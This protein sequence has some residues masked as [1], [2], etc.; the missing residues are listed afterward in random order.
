MTAS[1][2]VGL[3]A[4]LSGALAA[5]AG[6]YLGGLRL[7]TSASMPLGLWRVNSASAPLRRGDIVTACLPETVVVRQ[8]VRRGYLGPGV[9]PGGYE[10][11]IKPVAAAGGDVVTVGPAGVSVNGDFLKDTKQL[12]R[13]SAGR[14]LRGYPAGTYHLR[15]GQLFLL[16]PHNPRSFDSRYFGPVPV[17]SVLGVAHPLWV[18]WSW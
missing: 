12:R 18:G 2:R 7:N 8:A 5:L 6:G 1:R 13:D 11:V 9:C 17:S 4:G 10:P 15:V 14:P 3:A 16:A